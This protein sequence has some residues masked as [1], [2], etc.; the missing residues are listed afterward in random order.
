MSAARM[1]G[2][3]PSMSAAF[4]LAPFAI[5]WRM[6]STCPS[7]AALAAPPNEQQWLSANKD[8]KRRN[9]AAAQ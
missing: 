8:G 3:S 6:L 2:V 9:Y 4:T 7:S 5:S 1:S